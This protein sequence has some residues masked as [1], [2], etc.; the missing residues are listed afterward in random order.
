ML[1]QPLLVYS[2]L[3]LIVHGQHKSKWG[4]PAIDCKTDEISRSAVLACTKTLMAVKGSVPP[5]TTRANETTELCNPE[6]NDVYGTRVILYTTQDVTYQSREIGRLIH[7]TFETCT[8]FKF[9]SD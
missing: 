8:Q 2:S 4:R 3:L 6:K 5:F 7:H 9:A 1:W